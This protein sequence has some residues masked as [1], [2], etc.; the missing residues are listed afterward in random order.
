MKM[1]KTLFALVLFGV[2]ARTGITGESEWISLFNGKD[3]PAGTT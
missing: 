3:F 1:N 2:I